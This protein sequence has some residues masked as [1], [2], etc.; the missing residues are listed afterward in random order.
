MSTSF[1][2]CSFRPFRPFN[3]Y[4]GK[5]T[6]GVG[7][8]SRHAGDHIINKGALAWFCPPNI[9]VRNRTGVTQSNYL[10]LKR[11][12]ALYVNNSHNPANLN[13]NLLT[14]LDLSGCSIIMDNTGNIVPAK[15]SLTSIPYLDYTIDP[16]GVLFGNTIC[17]ATNFTEYVRYIDPSNNHLCQP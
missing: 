2:P 16:S 7:K 10:L 11:A 3:T 12:K 4:T 15:L 1:R 6:F 13:M 5:N 14:Q 8:T 17:G 9:C